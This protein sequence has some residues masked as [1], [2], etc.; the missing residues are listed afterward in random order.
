MTASTH[1]AKSAAASSIDYRTLDWADLDDAAELFART[2][3]MQGEHDEQRVVECADQSSVENIGQGAKD[4][5]DMAADTSA[6][7]LGIAKFFALHYLEPTTN[8]IAA[9]TPDGTLAG[10]A[11]VRADGQEPQF[12]QVATELTKLEEALDSQPKTAKELAGIK[13]MLAKELELEDE[14]HANDTTQGELELFV[15]NPDIRGCG[16][17]G[18]LWKHIHTY[19]AECGAT[20]YYLHT[21]SSCDVSFYQHKGLE[22]IAEHNDQRPGASAD[23]MYIY[24]G[25]VEA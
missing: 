24:R 16:V 14:S 21:D 22:C 17:G 13:E 12:P 20:Q 25:Q 2:W 15:V 10:V 7:A 8:A 5:E 23:M 9:Y 19:L 11:F 18:G 4:A 1:A 6:D 3:P